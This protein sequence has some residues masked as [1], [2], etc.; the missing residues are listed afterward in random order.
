MKQ[1]KNSMVTP[2]TSRSTN[3]II[4]IDNSK[5]LT[6]SPS[7]LSR[8]SVNTPEKSNTHEKSSNSP[9]PIP[10]KTINTPDKKITL[11]KEVLSKS[12]ITPR[13]SSKSPITTPRE[14]TKL[15]NEVVIPIIPSSTTTEFKLEEVINCFKIGIK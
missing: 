7:P 11:D 4:K 10:R 8:K 15:I 5:K 14:S 1:R 2:S 12:P 13:E 6:Q 9:S 3:T